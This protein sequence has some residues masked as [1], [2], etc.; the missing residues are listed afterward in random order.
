MLITFERTVQTI[1]T[2]GMFIRFRRINLLN[3]LRILRGNFSYICHIPLITNIS[4]EKIKR[5]C[6]EHNVITKKEEGMM[7]KNKFIHTFKLEWASKF[8]RSQQKRMETINLM[9]VS[10]I[11]CIYLY[12]HMFLFFTSCIYNKIGFCLN[13]CIFLQR[14]LSMVSLFDET[15]FTSEFCYFLPK[16]LAKKFKTFPL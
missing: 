6:N 3:S 7:W 12:I 16:L 9:P 10:K 8:L 11:A 1:F 2:P 15:L 13:F 14:N 4:W 5:S